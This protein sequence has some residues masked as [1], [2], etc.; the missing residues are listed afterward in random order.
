MRNIELTVLRIKNNE[1]Q[2]QAAKKLGVSLAYYCQIEN[3]STKA[4][5]GFIERFKKIYPNE[6]ADI[7][8]NEVN[9]DK[10]D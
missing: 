2:E 1:T 3:G 7:F 6:S 10:D 4:G 8:F 9:N 5:R